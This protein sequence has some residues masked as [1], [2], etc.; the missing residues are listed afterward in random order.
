MYVTRFRKNV[1]SRDDLEWV[2]RRSSD[3]TGATMIA[4]KAVG[5]LG[6]A[7]ERVQR[8]QRAPALSSA[9]TPTPT[10]SGWRKEGVA[11]GVPHNA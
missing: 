8:C 2:N 10:C 7:G 6:A 5:C 3:L 9:P 4:C 11:G 1:S